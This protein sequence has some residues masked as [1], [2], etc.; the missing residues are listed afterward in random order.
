MNVNEHIALWNQA[1]IKVLDIRYGS[2]EQ[3]AEM[4]SYRLPASA[5]LYVRSGYAEIKMDDSLQTVRRDHIVHGGRGASLYMLAEE[6]FEYYL[7]L[8]KAVLMLPSSSKRS[9]QIERDNPFQCAYNFVPA[10]PLPLLEKMERMHEDWLKHSPLDAFHARTL[11]YQFVHELLGQMQSQGAN[12]IQPDL[13]GQILRYMQDHYMNPITLEAMA[14][15]FGCSVSYLT[16]LFKQRMNESPIR[17]LNRIR[18]EM[19]ASYLIRSDY[20]LQAIAELV[21]YP[22]AH[23]FSR[24]FK[25][26]Y[27]IP[28]VQFRAKYG[29]EGF[30]SELPNLRMKSALVAANS[31]CYSVKD[32]E[33]YYHLHV[34]GGLQMKKVSKST[35]IATA[36]LLLCLTLFLSAC[37]SATN[38]VNTNA[39]TNG[40]SA[41]SQETVAETAKPSNAVAATKTYTDSKGEVTIP[42]DPERIIDLTGSAIG[43]L[44]AL[45]VTPIAATEDALQSPYH[46][47]KLADVINMGAEP[48]IEAILDLAPDLIIAFD[49]IE[50]AQY[51]NLVQIAPVVRLKYGNGTPQ[52]L[53]VEFGKITGKEEQAQDWISAWNAKIAEVKPKIA[54]V[55][56]DKTV[57]ILQPYAKGI[58]AWGNKGGR[59]GEIIHGD[60]GLKAPAIIQEKLIDGEEFGVSLTLELLPEY[61]GDYIFTSNWGWDDG[62]A[63]VVYGSPLWKTLPAVKNNQVYFIDQKGSYYNDPISLDAQLAFIV[64]SFLGK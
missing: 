47:D 1:S 48:N 8:Y 30:I 64:E 10:Y 7:I 37:S 43:N 32:N 55:V 57:S 54:E 61:A 17:F 49:Y 5:F 52:D 16:K 63:N 53:L 18:L 51:E 26:N 2:L 39:G 3:G 40:A 41:T 19:S 25:K 34:R 45:G 60:L 46:K 33:N 13:M 38:V 36:T 59:G 15:Q 20:S 28:P 27:G 44:L 6:A 29:G 4:K 22:D 21:G 14:E 42:A 62:D 23:T 56:G 35:S 9:R 24:S 11:F 50:E 58:Y 31:Q 12:P